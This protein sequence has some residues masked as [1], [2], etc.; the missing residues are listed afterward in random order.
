[1]L[2]LWMHITGKFLLLFLQDS[3]CYSPM[4]TI[5]AEIKA[6][7]SDEHMFGVISNYQIPREVDRFS[8]QMSS[9]C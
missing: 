3:Q 5:C 1:M 6:L 7:L 4:L 2:L 9:Y 8:A